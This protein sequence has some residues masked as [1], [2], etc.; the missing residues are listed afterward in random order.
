MEHIDV[1]LLA[2]RGNVTVIRLPWRKF[3]GVFIQGDSF[4][5]LEAA[6][7]A[8]ARTAP[9]VQELA[10]D[11]SKILALYAKTLNEHNIPLPYTTATYEDST[12]LLASGRLQSPDLRRFFELVSGYLDYD[13]DDSDW[14]A[15][16]TGIQGI[17]AFDYPLLGSAALTV[18][19]RQENGQENVTIA[20]TGMPNEALRIRLDTLFDVLTHEEK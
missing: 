1:E 18:R 10:D 14:M 13:F 7:R 8:A 9:E 5:I 12:E 17:P 15:I 19:V 4:S 16:T 6:A 20:V 2:P 3:P 11:L